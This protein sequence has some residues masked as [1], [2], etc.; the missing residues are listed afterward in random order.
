MIMLADFDRPRD[1]M[2]GHYTAARRASPVV[3]ILSYFIQPV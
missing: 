1:I 3:S 2:P